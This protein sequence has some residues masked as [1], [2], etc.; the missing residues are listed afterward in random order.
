MGYFALVD[1]MYRDGLTCSIC[2]LIM[3]ET[4]ELLARE[5][6]ISRGESDRYALESQQKAEGAIAG[7]V[8]S[9]EIAPL[10]FKDAKGKDQRL[11]ADEHPRAGTT[12]ES[13]AKAPLRVKK[14]MWPGSAQH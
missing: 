11:E 6:G 1:A 12:I 14:L 9:D 8:F 4:V 7:G 2:G 13:L 5:Y 3:G 10:T